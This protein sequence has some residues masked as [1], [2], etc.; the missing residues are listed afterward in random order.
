MRP[1]ELVVMLLDNVVDT[2]VDSHD[3]ARAQLWASAMPE[4]SACSCPVCAPAL[5]RVQEEVRDE[6][7]AG[8]DRT[9]SND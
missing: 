3:L 7:R 8:N 5:A 9:T 6:E 4:W 1:K 2:G